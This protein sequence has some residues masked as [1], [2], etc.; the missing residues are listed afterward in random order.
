MSRSRKHVQS[1][2]LNEY[3]EPE[4]NQSI[5]RVVQT[6][7]TNQIEAEYPNGERILVMLPTKFNKLVWTK[8]GTFDFWSIVKR[9]YCLLCA[10]RHVLHV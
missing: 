5:V 3:P 2:I 7:G 9:N 1:Q 4:P 10:V 6:R 8:K